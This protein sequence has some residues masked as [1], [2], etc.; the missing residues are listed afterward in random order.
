MSIQLVKTVTA[1]DRPQFFTLEQAIKV[2]SKSQSWL[3]QYGADT[4]V[5]LFGDYDGIVNEVW[6]SGSIDEHRMKASNQFAFMVDATLKFFN[7][8]DD[9]VLKTVVICEDC[10]EVIVNGQSRSKYSFHLTAPYLKTTVKSMPCLWMI[11]DEAAGSHEN[12]EN[13]V[14][15]PEFIPSRFFDMRVY[16]SPGT[17]PVGFTRLLR[18]VNQDKSWKG[19]MS[20]LKIY[21]GSIEQH[22]IQNVSLGKHEVAASDEWI[23][24]FYMSREMVEQISR[25]DIDMDLAELYEICKHVPASQVETYETW[26]PLMIAVANYYKSKGWKKAEFKRMAHQISMQAPDSYNQIVVDKELEKIWKNAAGRNGLG[27]IFYHVCQSMP[28]REAVARL[29]AAKEPCLFTP[30]D[31]EG[32]QVDTVTQLAYDVFWQQTDARFARFAKQ[33]LGSNFAAVHGEKVCWYHFRDHRWHEDDG[34]AIRDALCGPVLEC[35]LTKFREVKASTVQTPLREH[36]MS[37]E[38]HEGVITRYLENMSKL[39]NVVR[40]CADD[41][42]VD[43][44]FLTKMDADNQLLVFEDGVVDLRTNKFRD[45]T[46]EDMCSKSTGHK[47]PRESNPEIRSEIVTFFEQVHP[48][49]DIREYVL[50]AD[51]HHLAGQDGTDEVHY[52]VGDGANGKGV[53]EELRSNAL[54]DVMENG[55]CY[56]ADAKILSQQDG[57]SGSSS[58]ELALCRGARMIIVQEPKGIQ[59]G[60][61]IKKISGGGK[62]SA[63]QL[64]KNAS[65]FRASGALGVQANELPTIDKVDGGVKRRVRIIPH[66]SKFVDAPDPQNP[67]QFL[68]TGIRE[69]F[70]HNKAY[71]A[72]YLLMLLERRREGKGCLRGYPVP[73]QIQYVADDNITATI[74][75]FIDS[76]LHEMDADVLNRLRVDGVPVT[77]GVQFLDYSGVVSRNDIVDKFKEYS[78]LR[79]CDGALLGQLM[80]AV[81]KQFPN[82]VMVPDV[83]NPYVEG[84]GR[85][86]KRNVVW[87]IAFAA[88]W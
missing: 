17:D 6:G 27:T 57:S 79:R 87:G 24:Y 22:I 1:Y 48:E 51:A 88:S 70:A 31:V 62:I 28:G 37:P 4:W 14:I 72:E 78:K 74:E 35:L 63:R 76:K 71:G 19:S 11:A 34:K 82:A 47:F 66:T 73:Q 5:S 80:D 84:V 77:S 60:D 45:G 36:C 40:K 43:K 21:S 61:V 23:E 58:S 16:P 20:A 49:E 13:M 81:Q 3:E 26:M 85:K 68:R 33:F 38:M 41:F 29:L 32:I 86:C 46:P 59:R 64:F 2:L 25:P 42:G 39:V 65:T 18:A 15:L 55:Y 54:G 56:S 44:S 83:W 30:E 9:P 69:Q 67:R 52:E 75:S 50:T 10:R 7:L 53:K 8:P 12:T